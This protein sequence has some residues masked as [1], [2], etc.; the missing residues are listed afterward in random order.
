MLERF[1]REQLITLLLAALERNYFLEQKV[2]ELTARI[3]ELEAQLSQNSSN[4]SKPPSSDGFAKP[5]PKSRRKKSGKKPGGQP[6]H[7]GHGKRMADK[8][9]ETVVLAPEACPCCGESLESV[10]GRRAGTHYVMEIPAIAATVTKY[11]IEEKACPACGKAATAEFPHEA[12]AAQQYGPNLKALIVLLA[13]IGMVA[14]DRV[15]EILEAATGIAVSSGTVANAIE[16]CAKSLEGP[17]KSIKEAVT[18]ATVSHY[19]ESGMRS[20]GI[21]KWLHSASTSKLSYL[22]MHRKRGKEAMDD[23]GILSDFKGVAVHDCLASYWNYPC[24]HALCNAHLL[25]E[26]IFIG[27]TTGQGWAEEMIGL[28]LEI[29]EAVDL[30]RLDKKASLPKGGLSKYIKRYDALVAG[31]LVENPEQSKPAGRRGR[32][33]QTKARLLLLR[34]Q[35]HKDEWLRFAA[36]FNIPFDNNEAERN[37]RMAKVKQKVSGCFRS[38]EG[39]KSFTTIYSF[40]Q[41]LKKNGAAVFSEL[42]KVFKGNYSFPFQLTTE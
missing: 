34:L 17:V 11:I 8:A 19:D 15:A 32:A 18:G 1:D 26:L 25:R 38:D 22:E 4:S 40:I 27:E 31:G 9:T 10:A 2:A 37:L 29:K 21:L 12:A 13:E 3:A 28:L 33:K 5:A 24:I 6:L 36:D 39:E 42:V 20:Q 41:T 30:R 14:M 23:I 7:K 16:Q 35:G